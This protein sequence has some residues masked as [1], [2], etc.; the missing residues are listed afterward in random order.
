MT[1][2]YITIAFVSS[3]I[4]DPITRRKSNL[5]SIVDDDIMLFA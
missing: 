4:I 2:K 5:A 3:A 1:L